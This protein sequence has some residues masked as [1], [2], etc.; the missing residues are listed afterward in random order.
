MS[1]SAQLQ[2]CELESKFGFAVLNTLD[3]P[4]TFMTFAS[5]TWVLV[6]VS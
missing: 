1:I 2:L 3:Y 5:I 6:I 4:K